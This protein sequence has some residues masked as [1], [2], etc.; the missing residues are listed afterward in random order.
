MNAAPGVVAI[1]AVLPGLVAGGLA[2]ECRRAHA[3]RRQTNAYL[4]W[5]LADA[6]A[7]G[8]RHSYSC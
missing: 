6:R 4:R 3:A 7:A 5:V 1:A 2:R 8:N